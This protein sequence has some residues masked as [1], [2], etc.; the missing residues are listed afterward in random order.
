MSSV[1]VSL[2]APPPQGGWKGE[3]ERGRPQTPPLPTLSRHGKMN[4]HYE[5]SVVSSEHDVAMTFAA[6]ISRE[7]NFPRS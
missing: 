3:E 1:A 5:K 6:V 7:I 4:V 2:Q